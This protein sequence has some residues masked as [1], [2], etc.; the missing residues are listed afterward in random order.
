MNGVGNSG[1]NSILSNYSVT[2]FYQQVPSAAKLDHYLVPQLLRYYVIEIPDS[3]LNSIYTDLLNH[4]QIEHIS[5]LNEGDYLTQC[6][7]VI[8]CTSDDPESAWQLTRHDLMNVTEA[9]CLSEGQPDVIVALLDVGFNNSQSQSFDFHNDLDQNR[10]LFIEESAIPFRNNGCHGLASA[11][12]V[13]ATRNNNFGL[14]GSGGESSL[15]F[16]H[17]T[18][19]SVANDLCDAAARGASVITVSLCVPTNPNDPLEAD[20][21][22]LQ[23]ITDLGV[24][25]VST[26]GN[27][28]DSNVDQ[29]SFV[30]NENAINISSITNLGCF[31]TTYNCFTG[32]QDD[33]K[34]HSHNE[35]VDFVAQ[36]FCVS[37]LACNDAIGLSEG[38]SIAAPAVAGVIALIKSVNP[39]LV[40]SDIINLMKATQTETT[41]IEGYD[42]D[43]CDN[44]SFYP[45]GDIPGIPNA[46]HAVCE[47]ENWCGKPVSLSDQQLAQIGCPNGC[48]G[49]RLISGDLI[50]E[51]GTSLTITGQFSFA[52]CSRIIVKQGAILTIDGGLLTSCS[53]EWKGII[54]EGISGDPD[55]ENGLAGKVIMTNGA[56]IE[57]AKTAIS[58]EQSHIPWTDQMWGGYVRGENSTIRKC[59]RAVAFMKH[60]QQGIK[61]KSSFTKMNFVNLLHGTTTWANDGV[62]YNNC[63]F[64]NIERI[65]ML[66]HSSAAEVNNICTFVDVPIGIDV[67]YPEA[68]GLFGSKIKGNDFRCSTAGIYL[69]TAWGTEEVSIQE[70]LFRG[71]ENGV[72]VDGRSKFNMVSNT[73]QNQQESTLFMDSDFLHQNMITDNEFS[74]ATNGNRFEFDNG[75]ATFL[76]NCYSGIVSEDV[77]IIGS[78]GRVFPELGDDL[79]AAGNCFSK[80]G[81]PEINN[82]SNG[83]LFY[84][85]WEGH[86]PGSGPQGLIS[87]KYTENANGISIV[88]SDNDSGLDCGFGDEFFDDPSCEDALLTDVGEILSL[89]SIIDDRIHDM[90]KSSENF[91]LMK[92]EMVKNDLLL[93]LSYAVFIQDDVEFSEYDKNFLIDFYNNRPEFLARTI[94]PSLYVSEGNYKKA[95]TSLNAIPTASQLE[96]DYVKTQRVYYKYLEN[97]VESILASQLN[98]LK[99]IGLS[100]GPTNGYARSVYYLITG[101]RLRLEKPEYVTIEKRANTK[102]A[103]ER[104]IISFPNPVRRSILNI[105]ISDDE[106]QEYQVNLVNMDGKLVRQ[107]ECLSNEKLIIHT[108]EMSSGIYI[109]NISNKKEGIIHTDKI[110]VIE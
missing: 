85:I 26:S 82:A 36:G 79:I 80:Q 103:A 38:T 46:Y 70:N 2:A 55:N 63:L 98:L 75:G 105:N 44:A 11:G 67:L 49:D 14:S 27:G 93:N 32:G 91:D 74:N 48:S 94:V 88:T 110:I 25:Y 5:I 89:I 29:C 28:P 99:S 51:S 86:I 90:Q 65:G 35:T 102:T 1:I 57:N 58:M 101:E 81:I 60:G 24:T 84:N 22:A 33:I 31:Q 45:N 72:V 17:N 9:W 39:C 66:L 37:S 15:M 83:I 64:S 7:E 92:I 43:F 52:E 6:P 95:R 42:P 12:A 77:L 56:I 19:F 96:V 73:F 87:C 59:D 47:A 53:T 109:L 16:Y 54:V 10:V 40:T 76:R 104:K 97:G 21:A 3:Q 100:Q 41:D 69:S 8:P 106:L 108:D 61:D 68:F 18:G 107:V 78:G 71:G 4:N 34:H 62:R 20:V 50:V 23:C 30:M 13:G